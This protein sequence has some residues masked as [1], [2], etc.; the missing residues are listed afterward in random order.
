MRGQ[1][2][3][4]APGARRRSDSLSERFGA[5]RV[6][7]RK[8]SPRLYWG[9]LAVGAL[10]DTF[11][12]GLF[13]CLLTLPGLSAE[14]LAGSSTLALRGPWLCALLAAGL[15][16]VSWLAPG[17]GRGHFYYYAGIL[18]GVGAAVAASVRLYAWGGVSGCPTAWTGC[19]ALACGLVLEAAYRRGVVAFAASVGGGLFL[20]LAEQLPGSVPDFPPVA[21][22]LG[23]GAWQ[24]ARGLALVAACGALA[25][26]WA[27][28]N[29]TL[30]LVLAV[31]QRRSSAR[32]V[33]DGAYCALG[34]GVLLLAGALLLGGMPSWEP[35]EVGAVAA[36]VGFA[37]LLHARFAGW[38]QDLGLA[39]GCAAG[40]LALVLASCAAPALESEGLHGAGVRVLAWAVCVAAA[41]V[42]LA[43]HAV[44]RYWFTSPRVPS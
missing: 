37:F 25:V 41:N 12:A 42:S 19:V 24:T 1:P 23:G 21:R 18:C 32:V 13:A 44:R 15:L 31:P 4:S 28:G 3:T 43:L 29:M 10:L 34:L 8:R 40:F 22:L 27:L 26:A 6:Q 5:W 7:P 11:A 35:A 20:L 30:V 17:S 9:L 36:L 2:T 39:L 16:A 38:V 33:S 14:V